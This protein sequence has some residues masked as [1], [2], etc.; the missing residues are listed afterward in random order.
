MFTSHA[1]H[2][3]RNTE[4]AAHYNAKP[5]RLTNHHGQNEPA[6]M[7]RSSNY[8]KVVLPV[9]EALR[10]AHEIADALATHQQKVS[11]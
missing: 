7:I 2:Y 6:V 3:Q 1:E 4:E 9:S 11:A 8:I 5:A 10:L